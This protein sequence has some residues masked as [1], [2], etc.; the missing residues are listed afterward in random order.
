[1]SLCLI[2]DPKSHAFCDESIVLR[3]LKASRGGKATPISVPAFSAHTKLA[4]ASCRSALDFARLSPTI[5]SEPQ[6]AAT[7]VEGRDV[8]TVRWVLAAPA[9]RSAIGRTV[10]CWL[11][12][13]PVRVPRNWSEGRVSSACGPNSSIAMPRRRQWL[14]PAWSSAVKPLSGAGARRL[15]CA[16]GQRGSFARCAGAVGAR[17]SG[18]W[19]KLIWWLRPVPRRAL[20]PC[21]RRRD[22]NSR[23]ASFL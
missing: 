17:R 13:R 2:R 8:V 14:G 11:A 23:C 20:D 1:M 10:G 22:S 6:C 15:R 12:R 18:I 16:S 5:S 21:A 4:T 7:M 3:D 9:A 19:L